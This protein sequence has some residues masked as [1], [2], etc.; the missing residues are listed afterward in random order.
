[1]SAIIGLLFNRRYYQSNI[2]GVFLDATISETHE[3]TSRATQFP[4]EN[5]T[6]ISDHII[7]EPV[8]LAITGIVSDSPV[9]YFSFFNRSTDAYNRLVRIHELKERITVVTGIKVYNNMIL[10]SLTVPRD[11][12]TGQALNFV[13]EFQQIIIDTSAQLNLYQN[14][15]FNNEQQRINRDQVSD[16]N[17]YPNLENDP[18]LSLKDQATT[19]TNIG[20]QSL[21]P[22]PTQILPQVTNVLPLR[23]FY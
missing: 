19:Q 13:M 7:N 4:V 8:R 2:G 12:S 20:I 15:P 16:A 10:T 1:M 3:Y 11:N 6:M 5:G 9:R 23:G 18:S 22:V 21:Q 17:K 14:D